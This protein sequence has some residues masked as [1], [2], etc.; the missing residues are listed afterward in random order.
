LLAVDAK[1]QGVR[2]QAGCDHRAP[3]EDMVVL[4]GQFCPADATL[5]E[6][7]GRDGGERQQGA[8]QPG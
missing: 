8:G 5:G 1:L 2:Q 4:S 3:P 6:R 7:G